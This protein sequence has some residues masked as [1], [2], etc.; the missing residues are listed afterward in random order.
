MTELVEDVHVVSEILVEVSEDIV[1]VVVIVV[2][3]GI[4]VI[5][6]VVLV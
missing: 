2:V 5:V 4:V 1:A 3:V 6:V